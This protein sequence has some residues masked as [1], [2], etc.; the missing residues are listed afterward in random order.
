MGFI[1][2]YDTLSLSKF[3]LCLGCKVRIFYRGV[4]GNAPKE[5]KAG[6]LENPS[7]SATRRP[8]PLKFPGYSTEVPGYPWFLPCGDRTMSSVQRTLLFRVDACPGSP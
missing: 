3:S 1:A 2:L 8:S 4:G 5:G 7:S 6:K